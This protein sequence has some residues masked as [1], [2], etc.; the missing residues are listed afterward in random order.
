MSW[1]S[2]LSVISIVVWFATPILCRSRSGSKPGLAASR[3]RATSASAAETPANE[4]ADELRLRAILHAQ[5]APA[6]VRERLRGRGLRLLVVVLAVDHGREAVPRVAVHVLPDVQHAAAGRVHEHA[7]LRAQVRELRD[8]H[9][10]GGQ[11]HDV[12]RLDLGV[13]QLGAAV[14][15]QDADP[16]RGDPAVHLRVV[17]DLA[18]EEDPPLGEPLARLVG[19]LDRAVDAVAEAELARELDPDLA[20]ASDVAELLQPLDDLRV[21]ARRELRAHDALEVEALLEIR[22]LARSFVLGNLDL[23]D[24]AGMTA[25]A[26]TSVRE[27]P[28]ATTFPANAN[29]RLDGRVT[30]RRRAVTFR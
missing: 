27:A 7:T 25:D 11:D 10:E 20:G 2:R 17:D 24:T 22:L 29:R 19:V 30:K 26:R 14:V 15:G 12:S 3:K 4:V 13:A 28:R 16:E 6:G 8:G 18:G 23:Q 9:P 1:I 5:V 21:V